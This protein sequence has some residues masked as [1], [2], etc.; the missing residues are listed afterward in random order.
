M[1]AKKRGDE[2]LLES[3]PHTG[4]ENKNKYV[5]SDI[6]VNKVLSVNNDIIPLYTYAA[7]LPSQDRETFISS[8]NFHYIKILVK[9]PYSSDISIFHPMG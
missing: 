8:L 9:I 2:Q 4:S 7:P 6:S 1:T 5:V 3:W